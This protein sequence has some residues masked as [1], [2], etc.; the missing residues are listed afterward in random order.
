MKNNKSKI[1]SWTVDRFE[2][3]KISVG[4]FLTVLFAVYYL[5][6]DR[7]VDILHNQASRVV[8]VVIIIL[9][10]LVNFYFYYL[11]RKN[12]SFRYKL[13][14]DGIKVKIGGKTNFYRWSDIRCFRSNG[15][16]FYLTLKKGKIFNKLVPVIP[17]ENEVTYNKIFADLKLHIN[18]DTELLGRLFGYFLIAFGIISLGGMILFLI[19]SAGNFLTSILIFLGVIILPILIVFGARVISKKLKIDLSLL[20]I[21]FFIFIVFIVFVLASILLI[22]W[23]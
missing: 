3:K 22:F 21:L 8:F 15:E 16:I 4:L 20:F 6:L 5:L 1:C 12:K 10:F 17:D 11:L 9:F 7:F 19:Y 23:R 14:E 2:T 13:S 18:Y